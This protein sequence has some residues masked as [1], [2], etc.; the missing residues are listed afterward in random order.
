[1]LK[2]ELDPLKLEYEFFTIHKIKCINAFVIKINTIDKLKWY[3]FY[4]LCK[5]I[6]SNKKFLGPI[7][8]RIHR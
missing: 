8:A 4:S 7:T 1:M 3:A 2:F 5:K 6:I